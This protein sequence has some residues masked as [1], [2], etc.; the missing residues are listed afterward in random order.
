MIK[1]I[2]ACLIL[3]TMLIGPANAA[4]VDR[5]V[6]GDTFVLADGEKVRILGIDAPEDDANS[7]QHLAGLIEGQDV[8]LEQEGDKRDKYGRMLAYVRLSC[9]VSG[10]VA[11][12]D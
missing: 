9:T 12:S 4:T 7:T 1:A 11:R 3:T 5:V 2:L 6:D 10:R 8:V